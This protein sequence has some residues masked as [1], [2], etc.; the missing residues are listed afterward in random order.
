MIHRGGN[1]AGKASHM[2]GLSWREGLAGALLLPG[3]APIMGLG[4]ISGDAVRVEGAVLMTVPFNDVTDG[5]RMRNTSS[6][7]SEL[8][9]FEAT[10]AAAGSCY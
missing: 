8:T 6:L 10:P 3:L 7:P 4:T 9:V 5:L 2:D 1:E